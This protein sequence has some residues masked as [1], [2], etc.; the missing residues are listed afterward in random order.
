MRTLPGHTTTAGHLMHLSCAILPSTLH[1]CS[2]L[3]KECVLRSGNISY[4]RVRRPVSGHDIVQ[5]AWMSIEG[6]VRAAVRHVRKVF[7]TVVVES[8]ARR[9]C[10]VAGVENVHKVAR[11][12]AVLRTSDTLGV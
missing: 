5:Q 1:V 11:H 7:G 12:C 10:P 4:S 6:R 3:R 8:R 2:V 9:T